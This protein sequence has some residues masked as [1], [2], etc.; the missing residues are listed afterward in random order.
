MNHVP[1]PGL[2]NQAGIRACFRIAGPLV[3]LVAL[4]FMVVGGFDFFASMG[5]FEEPDK[6]WMLFVGIPLLAVGGWLSQAGY[7]GAAARYA[8]G[9]LAPVAKDSAAYLTDGEGLLGMGRT[10]DDRGAAGTTDSPGGGPF[11][12][13]CG[14]RN[15]SDARYCDGCG[16]SVV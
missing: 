2:A 13:C 15:D 7:A 11:C 14:V 6:F 4:G 16:Q 3:L 9:E 12:R 8:S 10:V 1:N 5:S